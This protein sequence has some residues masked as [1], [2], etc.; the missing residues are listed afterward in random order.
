MAGGPAGF[1]RGFTCPA[2]LGSLL[3]GRQHACT[4]LSP[5]T[6]RLSR[7]IHFA[8]LTRHRSPTTPV[9]PEPHGF[10]LCP[11]RSPLLG[12]SLLFSLPPGTKMFQFPGFASLTTRQGCQSSGLAGCPIRTSADQRSPAPPRGLSQLAASFIAFRSQ[13]IRP[14]P[15]LAFLPKHAPRRRGRR[16]ILRGS[17]LNP[18]GSREPASCLL[19]YVLSLQSQSLMLRAAR[20]KDLSPPRAR[21]RS[22][23]LPVPACQ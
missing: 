11:V 18:T 21:L 17:T 3:R 23:S 6:A 13:G 19:L 7:R 4:G 22:C 2:L 15:F 9:R 5:S 20:R 16:H 14:A 8:A 12:V 1:T 10:G